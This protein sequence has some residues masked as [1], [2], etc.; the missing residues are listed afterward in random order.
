MAVSG[1]GGQTEVKA[2]RAA[3]WDNRDYSF[4]YSPQLGVGR[5]ALAKADAGYNVWTKALGHHLYQLVAIARTPGL[6]TCID[7]EGVWAFLKEHV[8]TPVQR[9]WV[10]WLMGRLREEER[11]RALA[12]SGFINA[13][14]IA[15][16][17]E[18]VDGLV[19]EGLK[20]GKLRIRV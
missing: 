14:Y 17:D 13:G 2:W 7:E 6:L 19:T 4:V 12:C 20:S 3:V 5:E 9:E 11:L 15:C 8:T 10:P 16:D 1:A 18:H